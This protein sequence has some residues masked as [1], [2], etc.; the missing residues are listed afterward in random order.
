MKQFLIIGLGRF[1]FSIAKTLAQ[2]GHDVLAIDKDQKKVHDIS[3]EVTHAVVADAT[4][5]N[6]LKTLGVRNF[7]AAIISIGDNLHSNIL[8]TLVLKELGVSY[9]IVKAQ[10][11]IHAKVL[12]KAGADRVVNPEKDMG[13]RL[14]KNIVSTNILDY[15]EFARDHSIAEVLVVPSMVG[16]SLKELEFRK[17]YNLNVMAIKRNEKLNMNPG[18]EDKIF[19]NDSIIVMGSNESLE[20]IRKIR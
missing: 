6:T 7:D 8:S 13:E 2:H 10:D 16:K 1:G 17:K 18:A 4:D 15:F 5:E 20:K 14:A 11:N 3:K 19:E 12:I 9:V